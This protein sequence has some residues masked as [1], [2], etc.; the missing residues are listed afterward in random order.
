MPAIKCDWAFV[1]SSVVWDHYY[2][3][4]NSA[5]GQAI[6]QKRAAVLFQLFFFGEKTSVFKRQVPAIDRA[7]SKY[8]IMKISW[9]RSICNRLR[10]NSTPILDIAKEN[11]P[12]CPHLEHYLLSGGVSFIFQYPVM[13][14]HGRLL[15][16]DTSGFN[17]KAF[18]RWILLLIL[19]ST[20]LVLTPAACHDWFLSVHSDS[21]TG[22]V[23]PHFSVQ[24]S[25]KTAQRVHN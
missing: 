21:I 1:D 16:P 4:C 20:A 25:Y 17:T 23:Q 5:G 7:L 9:K 14:Q 18:K 19:F 2:F 3:T 10:C 11:L 22:G 24:L 15:H 6:N 12:L 13:L 8:F